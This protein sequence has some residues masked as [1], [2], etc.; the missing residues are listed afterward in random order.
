MLL[1][2]ECMSRITGTVISLH[3]DGKAGRSTKMCTSRMSFVKG[4]D[5]LSEI[6]ERDYIERHR[7][8]LVCLVIKL[9]PRSS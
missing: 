6:I 3:G 1:Q 5:G 9:I 8:I 7:C 2:K 4:W